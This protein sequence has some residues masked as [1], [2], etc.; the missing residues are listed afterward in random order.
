MKEH[1]L[2]PKMISKSRLN[3]RL[4]SVAQLSYELFHQLGWAFKQV[5]A[6]TEYLIDSFPVPVCENILHATHYI[7]EQKLN[8]Y[9][10]AA[11]N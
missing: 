2:I 3:R 1:G 11:S 9:S 8:S 6:S 4:H 7:R 5:N 10:V